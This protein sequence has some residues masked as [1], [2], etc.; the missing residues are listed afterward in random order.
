MRKIGTADL[1]VFPLCLGG[2]VFGWTA[3]EEASFQILDV[4]LEAGG[5]FID[6]ADVYGEWV[7]GNPP[8]MSESIIGRWLAERGVR[9]RIVLATKVGQAKGLEGLGADVIRT[10]AEAS[11]R[12]LGTDRIDL[13]YAHID[14]GETPL[15]ETLAAFDGLVREGKVRYVAASNITAPRLAQALEISDRDGHARYVAVQ[16]HYNLVHLQEYELDLS[17]LCEREG[18]SC[19][20]YSAL[21]DGFLTGKYRPGVVPDSERV[22]EA[23]EYTNED[24]FR[25]LEVLDEVAANH[26]APVPAVALAWLSDRPTVAA[27]IASARTPAQLRDLL[28]S[29]ELRL[30]E[31]EIEI[32]R[33]RG[34]NAGR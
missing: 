9:D 14:D 19:L 8:G 30:T 31:D 4:Y 34:R 18:L 25:L 16:E 29:V 12:R 33:D 5:N 28:P 26:D 21:A 2:N 1:E 17:S 22:E 10:A 13:Y 27:P 11:L 23:G 3:D 6:T 15:E 7:D 24:G 20:A 32:L